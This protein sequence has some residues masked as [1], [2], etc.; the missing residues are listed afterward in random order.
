MRNR[1]RYRVLSRLPWPRYR[2][3][4]LLYA[5]LATLGPWLFAILCASRAPSAL[6]GWAAAAFGLSL[7]ALAAVWALL[8]P[9]GLAIAALSDP[10]RPERAAALPR[11]LGGE[12]GVLVTGIAE[13]ASKIVG[14]HHRWVQRH[15]LTALPTREFLLVQI[16]EDIL[17]IDGE[18]MLGVV[19]FTDY[20]RLAAF[21]A[22]SAELTLKAFAERLS[23]LLGKDRP[24]AHVDRD[25]FAIWFRGSPDTRSAASELQSIC[26]ALGSELSAGEVRL[27][28]DI[29]AGAAIFPRDA[30]EPG[31]LVSRALVSLAKPGHASGA[32]SDFVTSSARAKELFGLEQDLRHAISREQLQL[33]FQPVVDLGKRRLVGAEALLRWHHPEAGSIPPSRFVPILEEAGLTDEIGMWTLNAACREARNWQRQ[34]L[35]GLKV[36]VNLSATQLH[37][38]GLKQMIA[39]TLERHKLHAKSLELELTETAATE[40][41]ER[42]FALF[43]ELRAMGISLAIDDFGSGYSSLSYVKNLPFDKLKIDREFV[44][45]VHERRDSQAICRSLIELCRGLGIK[46]LAEGVETEEEVRL[47]RSFGCTLFQGYYFARPLPAEEFIRRAKD[48]DWPQLMIGSLSQAK[49][50][51][52]SRIPA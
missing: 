29:E 11:D 6:F 21:D 5:F 38:R 45:K 13:I 24:L 20:D 40:D 28:P 12:A 10:A 31:A 42:T 1:K 35:T 32:G 36:A 15:P 33:H 27:V 30:S 43:G 25:C 19:R 4:I 49:A 18:M 37:D 3:Q 9:I 51:F 48:Q 26:Y 7:L 17:Q 14:L 41:A 46:L 50:E 52:K 16:A 47:L 44:V 22:P 8:R 2:G 34:G 23:G 39:R